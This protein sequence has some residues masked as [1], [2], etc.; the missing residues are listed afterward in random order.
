MPSHEAF[1]NCWQLEARGF[2]AASIALALG[3]ERS[4]VSLSL[5]TAALVWRESRLFASFKSCGREPVFSFR[6]ESHF[7]DAVAMSEPDSTEVLLNSVSSTFSS[8]F[9]LPFR[10]LVLVSCGILC[11]ALNLHVLHLLGIDTGLILDIRNAG[12]AGDP[13]GYAG[14]HAHPSKLYRGV[15][16]LAGFYAAWTALCWVLGFQILAG[17]D[18]NAF[19]SRVVSGFSI[20]M[21]IV[22]LLL[23]IDKLKKQ[24]RSMFLR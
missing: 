9:P 19:T 20:A 3:D 16:Q 7:D 6:P 12:S 13:P 2:G 11:W 17:G 8:H 4:R 23:P 24:E 18:G 1:A 10:I 22:F 5:S 21:A 15:Y 14:S